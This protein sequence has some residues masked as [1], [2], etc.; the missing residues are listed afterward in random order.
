[1][2]ITIPAGLTKSLL[3]LADLTPWK[4]RIAIGVIAMVSHTAIDYW[5]PFIKEKETREY[6]AI[7]SLIK[8][9]ITMTSGVLSRIA[10]QKLGEF[11]V[12]YDKMPLPAGMDKAKFAGAVGSV[13]SIYCALIS[14]PLIEMPIISNA[15]TYVMDKFIKKKSAN[16]STNLK[17]VNLNA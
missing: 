3:P 1:M 2:P 10:G 14:V 5:S 11:L 7:R 6:A 12:K 9:F 16:V 8:M 13:L 15:V 4:Q 17:K